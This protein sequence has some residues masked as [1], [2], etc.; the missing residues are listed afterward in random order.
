MKL[1]GIDAPASSSEL[2]E[3]C[4]L[5]NDVELSSLI[6]GVRNISN[7][8]AVQCRLTATWFIGVYASRL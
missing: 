2:L 8:S 4:V 3:H 5:G 1:R 7:I 6:P